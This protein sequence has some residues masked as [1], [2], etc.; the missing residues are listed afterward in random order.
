[1]AEVIYSLCI[2]NSNSTS[3]TVD[4]V[5]K[6]SLESFALTPEDG[7]AKVG[8]VKLTLV[9]VKY[10]KAIYQPG[11]VEAHLQ[12]SVSSKEDDKN[13]KVSS[14][15]PSCLSKTFKGKKVDLKR[16]CDTATTIIAD[17]YFV[18]GVVP[19]FHSGDSTYA[20]VTLYAFSPD[21]YLTLSQYCKAYVGKR[22]GRDIFKG[23]M[24]NSPDFTKVKESVTLDLKLRCLDYEYESGLASETASSE[25]TQQNNSGTGQ[26]NGGTNQQQSTGGGGNGQQPS[27]TGTTTETKV[28]LEIIHPYLVQYNESFYDFLVRTANRCGEFLYYEGGKLTL[29]LPEVQK[30]DAKVINSYSTISYASWEETA[31]YTE[32]HPDYGKEKGDLYASNYGHFFEGPADENLMQIKSKDTS[33]L[34]AIGSGFASIGVRGYMSNMFGALNKPT[35]SEMLGDFSVSVANDAIRKAFT[36]SRKNKKFNTDNIDSVKEHFTVAGKSKLNE[37]KDV[38]ETIV[39][40]FSNFLNPIGMD[41][42]K[43]VIEN[44][45]KAAAGAVHI[46]FGKQSEVLLLGNVIR[47]GNSL[48]VVTRVEGAMQ[49]SETMEVD[50]VLM[51]DDKAYPFPLASGTVRQ[52]GP[53]LAYVKSNSDP[54]DLGRVRILYPWQKN[55]DD[56]SPWVRVAKTMASSGAGFHFVPDEGDEV[57]V[58]YEGGN[59][60]RPYVVGALYSERNKP[61]TGAAITSKNGHQIIFSSG[62]GADF[63]TGALPALGFVR[64]FLKDFAGVSKWGALE[65]NKKLGGGIELTDTYGFY[66]IKM[67]TDSRSI[68]I[69]SPF[70][71]VDLS[72]FTGITISAPNGNVKIS[73]KNVSIEAGNELSLTSGKNLKNGTLRLGGLGESWFGGEDGALKKAALGGVKT[74][75]GGFLSGLVDLSLLRTALETFLKP[76]GGTLIIKSNRY[77]HLEAGGGKVQVPRGYYGKV[78]REN[79]LS[80]IQTNT[81]YLVEPVK[82]GVRFLDGMVDLYIDCY[83]AVVAE[84]MLYDAILPGADGVP[85]AKD[86]ITDALQHID[87]ESSDIDESKYIGMDTLF[88]FAKKLEESVK[89]GQNKLIEYWNRQAALENLVWY[90]QSDK[91]TKEMKDY[92]KYAKEKVQNNQGFPESF[93]FNDQIQF[94]TSQCQCEAEKLLLKRKFMWHFIQKLI[95]N[96]HL[97]VDPEFTLP[98]AQPINEEN[99]TTDATNWADYI[100]HLQVKKLKEEFSKGKQVVDFVFD[101]TGIL[102]FVEGVVGDIDMWSATET[103][104]ILLSDKKNQTLRFKGKELDALSPSEY[105]DDLTFFKEKLNF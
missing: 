98:Q 97:M 94:N 72:A 30:K 77:L 55:D 103:G 64:K 88:E 56:A 2:H 73:G 85:S 10:E 41:F 36:Q 18:F 86:I 58:D 105:L 96:K 37:Q 40:P 1:M 20:Y 60:E 95:E 31:A 51:P 70:G 6:S 65:N 99:V 53:Q 3:E 38:T 7:A 52:S 12:I 79:E 78:L 49:S 9:S 46:S 17:S 61:N 48:Y 25:N 45:R 74:A 54:L 16:K 13:F 62:T 28:T 44:E 63:L 57:L 50:A 33:T 59:I 75:V 101:K 67:S 22:L 93:I 66:S 39:S 69:S 26:N 71:K 11:C 21:K 4:E 19:R 81:A 32:W 90:W 42:Y 43:G 29:G 87:H 27:G 82:A 34:S 80:K 84:K 14:I 8:K 104:Q 83:Q 68:K 76:V 91:M 47:L 23:D 102:N 35:L 89:N 15:T 24:L 100:A 5:S 92:L